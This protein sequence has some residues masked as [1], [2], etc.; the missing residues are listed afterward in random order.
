MKKAISATIDKELVKWMEKEL[1]ENKEYRNK[2][3][4]IEIALER[5]KHGKKE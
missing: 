4:I 2:S 3:H 5:L 1:K